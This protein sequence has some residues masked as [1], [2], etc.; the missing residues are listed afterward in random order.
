MEE[1]NGLGIGWYNS[2]DP[3]GRK[4]DFDPVTPLALMEY[5]VI[6]DFEVV[7]F[8]RVILYG[9]DDEVSAGFFGGGDHKFLYH[10]LFHNPQWWF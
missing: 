6:P 2:C 3:P 4:R 8:R 5:R 10:V 9:K 1:H 7:K